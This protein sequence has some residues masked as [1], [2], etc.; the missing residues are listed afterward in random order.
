MTDIEAQSAVVLRPIRGLLYTLVPLFVLLAA[1]LLACVLAY[2]L[3][4]TWGDELSF[5]SVLKK[6]TQLFL[7]LSICPAMHVL[8]LSKVDLGFSPKSLFFKQLLQGAGLG[9][10][11]LMPVF[12]T[13]YLLDVNAIDKTQP[14]TLSWLSK[15]LIVE[16]LL[17]LLISFFEEPLF[18]GVLL[19]GLC[20]K[21]PVNTAIVIS[22]VYYAGLHFLDSKTQIPAQDLNLFSGFYLL[23]AAF[24]NLLN[25]EILSAFLALFT[26]G[27]FLGLLRTQVKAS[28]GLCIGC[29][30]C[31]VWQIKLSKTLFNINPN[32]DYLFLTNGHEGVIGPLVTIW[33]AL[34][35]AGYFLYRRLH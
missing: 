30:A 12:V 21:L 2:F 8:K 10:I 24:V 25:P 28:L 34:A 16:L 23:G 6:A 11:T 22:A 5:R 13:L 14:W 20:R 29:H 31:W 32:S 7:V 35:I 4:S 33:L 3:V 19:I 1:T 17:A 15:K 27:V 26:V 9:L 18:R